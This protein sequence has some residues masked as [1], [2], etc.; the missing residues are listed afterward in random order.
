VMICITISAHYEMDVKQSP[1]YATSRTH[2]H[3]KT[4]TW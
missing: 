4:D 3:T 2:H 1:L